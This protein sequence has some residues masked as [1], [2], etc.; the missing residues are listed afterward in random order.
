MASFAPS[1]S[2]AQRFF[3]AIGLAEHFS[4][5]GLSQ[6]VCGLLDYFFHFICEFPGSDRGM[7]RAR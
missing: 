3:G 6:Q 1:E 7:Q 5:I 4:D 2:V